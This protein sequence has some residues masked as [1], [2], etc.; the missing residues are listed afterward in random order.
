[1]NKLKE[2]RTKLEMSQQKLAEWFNCPQAKVSRMESGIYN[3]P[4]DYVLIIKKLCELKS[5]DFIL[6]DYVNKKISPENG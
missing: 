5:V 1:M 3:I 2:V 6:E 4:I